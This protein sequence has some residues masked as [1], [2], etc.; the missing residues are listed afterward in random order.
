LRDH[1]LWADDHDAIF[2]IDKY[3]RELSN[4]QWYYE[5]Q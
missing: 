4:D 1:I 2:V 5:R 3:L